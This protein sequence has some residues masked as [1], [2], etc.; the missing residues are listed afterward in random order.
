MAYSFSYDSTSGQTPWPLVWTVVPTDFNWEGSIG[1]MISFTS[2]AIPDPDYPAAWDD[3]YTQSSDGMSGGTTSAPPLPPEPVVSEYIYDP[4]STMEEMYIT[5]DVD[6]GVVIPEFKAGIFFP[7]ED[8]RYFKNGEEKSAQFPQE[9]IDDGFDYVV[10]LVP[11]SRAFITKTLTVSVAS[12][13]TSTLT[14]NFKFRV[15]NDWSEAKSTLEAM[16]EQ[17]KQYFDQKAE[18]VGDQEPPSENEDNAEET[19]ELS[20]SLPETSE[21]TETLSMSENKTYDEIFRIQNQEEI[22]NITSNEPNLLEDIQKDTNS[23]NVTTTDSAEFGTE[24]APVDELL[25]NN[26]IDALMNDHGYSYDEI[27]GMLRNI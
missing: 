11:D 22:N 1:D 27:I 4:S 23:T 7:Y 5:L 17:S 10:A 20:P 15:N 19:S 25:R 2:K 12:T 3:H 13:S 24:S 6:D 8:V 18:E 16:S 9:A 26:D 14:G 21:E